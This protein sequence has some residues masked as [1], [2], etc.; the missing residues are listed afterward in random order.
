MWPSPD[1]KSSGSRE[2]IDET[3]D[4]KF[5]SDA[6]WGG[7][8][9]PT[10]GDAGSIFRRPWI[11]NSFAVFA[12]MVLLLISVWIFLDVVRESNLQRMGEYRQLLG[13]DTAAQLWAKSI[14]E[15]D[16]ALFQLRDVRVLRDLKLIQ[17][18]LNEDGSSLSLTDD[19]LRELLALVRQSPEA[20]A[21]A[22][23]DL[24]TEVPMI[25]EIRRVVEACCRS[26][27]EASSLD[28]AGRVK[29]DQERWLIGVELLESLS[30]GGFLISEM[31]RTAVLEVAMQRGQD[32]LG[33]QE[34][35]F[36][37]R[38]ESALSRIELPREAL[39]RALQIE[40]MM[41][42]EMTEDVLLEDVSSPWFLSVDFRCYLDR[43]IPI[44][45]DPTDPALLDRY[46]EEPPFYAIT[47]RLMS[48]SMDSISRT[49]RSSDA[50]LLALRSAFAATAAR[51]RGVEW[52]PPDG[53]E[54]IEA[55][56]GLSPR[57]HITG[58]PEGT[59]IYLPR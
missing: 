48:L 21:P 13:A 41:S 28:E 6:A 8:V 7:T 33:T 27:D 59:D 46:R 52:Q 56:G 11:R 17:D 14:E 15:R 26:G 1:R 4:H 10:Q 32:L 54:L 35:A 30:S 24:A 12:L 43:Q 34:L 39:A 9:T 22:T 31:I 20:Q 47:T 51:I 25:M 2:G 44:S 3:T 36:I 57:I 53:V 45:L 40:T 49:I 37:E 42:F 38:S 55:S 50:K 23:V 19:Q 16:P 18:Q 58:A 29:S 5:R